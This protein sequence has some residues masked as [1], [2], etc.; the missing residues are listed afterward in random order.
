MK[1]L[2]CGGRD[3]AGHKT[4][5]RTLYNLFGR[6]DVEAIIEG[7]HRPRLDKNGDYELRSADYLAWRWATANEMPVVTHP[8]K[9]SKHGARRKGNPAGPIRNGEMLKM[10]QPDLVLAFPGGKGTADMVRQARAAGVEV[11][12]VKE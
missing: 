12:E 5:F 7:G 6:E 11:C 2:V 1:V 9:W 4:V 8:A 10:W 3:Y